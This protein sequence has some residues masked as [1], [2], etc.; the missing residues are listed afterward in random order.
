[1]VHVGFQP[2]TQNA[3]PKSPCCNSQRE[4][5]GAH[6]V[7]CVHKSLVSSTSDGVGRAERM[8][9]IGSVPANGSSSTKKHKCSARHHNLPAQT[10][11]L[12]YRSRVLLV[13]RVNDFFQKSLKRYL[14]SKE[15]RSL[16]EP[17]EIVF[18]KP[19][20][21]N[22]ASICSLSSSCASDLFR[23]LTEWPDRVDTDELP[24]IAARR[25]AADL[26]LPYT[27]G[28]FNS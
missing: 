28:P 9:P 22:Q 24:P 16:H 12:E 10:S 2:K 3:N 15:Q 5:A 4:R 17:P 20:S 27:V 7:P 1:V 26:K 25:V 11:I 14:C 23:L 19:F 18:E 13:L 8:F 21:S 6:S